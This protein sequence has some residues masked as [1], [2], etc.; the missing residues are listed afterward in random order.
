[1]GNASEIHENAVKNYWEFIGKSLGSH[2]KQ[3]ENT[4]FQNTS[5]FSERGHVSRIR[6]SFP[7]VL[8]V[9]DDDGTSLGC[10]KSRHDALFGIH[11]GVGVTM[12][13]S[14]CTHERLAGAT[15]QLHWSQQRALLAD[16]LKFSGD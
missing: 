9:P 15:S 11:V 8:L 13:P 3:L 2:S 14:V 1:M 7:N 6:A 4:C 12:M 10:S 16:M 5:T